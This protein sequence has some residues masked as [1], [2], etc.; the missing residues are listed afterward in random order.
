MTSTIVI[1]SI[2]GLIILILLIGVPLRFTRFIGEGIVRLI[3]GALFIFLI[4]IVGNSIGLHIPINMITASITG[5]LGIP[6][7]I[8]LLLVQKYIIF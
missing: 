5:F 6:G 1:L 2:I 3:I 8:A 4:N 7:I